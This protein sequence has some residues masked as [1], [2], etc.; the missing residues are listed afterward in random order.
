MIDLCLCNFDECLLLAP[1]QLSLVHVTVHILNNFFLLNVAKNTADPWYLQQTGKKLVKV[2]IN[3]L[4]FDLMG[5]QQY[6]S[7]S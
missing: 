6:N 5:S 1:C 2:R 3:I 4:Q 7:L